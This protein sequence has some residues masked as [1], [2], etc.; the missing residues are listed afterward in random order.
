MFAPTT[1]FGS[2]PVHQQRVAGL[3]DAG[4]PAVLD[5]D[6][7]LDD[8]LHG[9]DHERVRDHEVE[10]PLRAGHGAV[11][12]E[13]VAQR[14]AAAEDA[15]VAGNQIVALDLRPELRVAQPDP[16]ADRRPEQLDVLLPRHPPGHCVRPPV[17]ACPR[18]LERRG[19]LRLR[20]PAL[21]QAVQP[22]H[23]P[24]AAEGDEVDLA[25]VARLEADGGACRNVEPHAEG[26]RTGEVELRVDLE[27]VEVRADLHRAVAEVAH[28]E[29]DGLA[30]LVQH[31]VAV[32][33]LVLA[34]LDTG[35]RL[36]ARA[37]R[38]VDRHELLPVGEHRLDLERADELRHAR[39]DVVLGQDRG[40][41]AHQLGDVLPVPGALADLVRDQG[42]GLGVVQLQAAVS[43]PA[44]ELGGEKEQQPIRLLRAQ[45]HQTLPPWWAPSSSRGAASSSRLV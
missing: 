5:A 18:A 43:P 4:D 26:L 25:L 6:V 31:D 14:L 3:A 1:R 19:Q 41:D 22:V 40:A 8:A 36:V 29:P 11:R 15:L 42:P 17:A 10:R 16:V 39:Q 44:R 37:D 21:G 7:G 13:P 2:T 35:G 12:T 9:V 34:R 24:L 38:V 27:E 32:G 28:R 23:P 45:M 33:Q 30:A 20:R